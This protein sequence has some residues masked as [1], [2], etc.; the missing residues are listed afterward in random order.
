[1]IG[2]VTMQI[3]KIL[4]PHEVIKGKEMPMNGIVLRLDNKAI[5][6]CSKFNHSRKQNLELLVWLPTQN[7]WVRTYEKNEYTEMMWNYYRKHQQKR[8]HDFRKYENM[9]KHDR[10]HKGGGG[11]SRIYNGSITDYECSKNPMH[12]FRRVYN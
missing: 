1:M 11:G 12:D 10:R 3:G 2:G 8:N 6:V 7:K 4:M 9:M 5:L